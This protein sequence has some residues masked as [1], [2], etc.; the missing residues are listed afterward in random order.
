MTL[1][2]GL[3]T[4]APVK[5]EALDEHVMHEER[6]VVGAEAAE[7]IA[8]ARGAGGRVFAVGTTSLRV[9]ESVAAANAGQV[10][11]GAGRTRLFAY[12]PYDFQVVD[13]LVTNFHLPRSTLLMLVSALAAPG[14]TEGANGWEGFTRRQLRSG[15]A[16]SVTGTRCW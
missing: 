7:A 13:A 9:L 2:V 14:G 3:G 12:P 4:F 16:F 15:I 10:V 1:H 5:A 6:F 8:Q 11:A